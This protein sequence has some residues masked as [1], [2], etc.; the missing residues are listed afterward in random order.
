M[1]RTVVDDALNGRAEAARGAGPEEPAVAPAPATPA[2][3]DPVPSV[4]TEPPAVSAPPPAAAAVAPSKPATP[5]A[6]APERFEFASPVVSVSE[7]RASVAV[8]IRRRGGDLGD[9]SAVWWTSDG[10][11]SAP[12]DYVGFGATIEKFAAG[13]T[14]RTIHIPIVGD[15]KPERRENFFVNLRGRE[16]PVGG[17]EPAQRVEIVILDDD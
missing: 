6:A 16:R 15:S 12:E 9:S 7:S 1:A 11:A 4:A 10:S 3:S 17:L 8:E 13:E 2:A 14:V 5:V